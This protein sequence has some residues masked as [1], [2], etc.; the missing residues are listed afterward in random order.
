[1]KTTPLIA[2]ILVISVYS[3]QK[4]DTVPGLRGLTRAPNGP[5]GDSTVTAADTSKTSPKDTVPTPP[6]PQHTASN[7][8]NGSNPA[9]G[10]PVAPIYGDTIIFTQPTSGPDYVVNPVNPP[11]T[12]KYFSW[13][14]G[15][16]LNQNT[17]A[18]D[19]TQSQTG[20]KYMIGFV[21]DGSKDTCLSYLVVGGAAYYDSVYVLADND[22]TASPYFE[23]NPYLPNICQ[24]GGCTFD[25]NGA[26]AAKKVIV[27]KTTGVI[28]LD[29][30]LNGTGLLSLGGAFGLLPQDGS[31]I[32]V[33]I[34]YK[35]NDGS[36][37]ALQSIT[38]QIEYYNSASS[39][40]SGLLGG[41]V[42]SL[43][44]LLS[45]NLISTS[46]NPR[47]PLLIITRRH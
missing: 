13:P 17:G 16:V 28:Q 40:N 38:V 1:M 33:P 5:R 35:L 32:T 15:M 25:V 4:V 24:N 45:G 37:Q 2:L 20:M 41:I 22:T 12:G 7:T 26:A 44:S 42:N 9:P 34:Y 36:N 29:K 27:N 39:I 10:C 31:V 11:G 30:T 46:A 18:I 23:A 47:P 43:N 14:V 19:L 21:A 3:C 6:F 8:N